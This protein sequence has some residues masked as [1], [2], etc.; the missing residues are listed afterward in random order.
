MADANKASKIEAK[1]QIRNEEKSDR[2]DEFGLGV[3]KQFRPDWLDAENS[4]FINKLNFMSKN[5]Q[6]TYNIVSISDLIYN[7][8]LSDKKFKA[9]SI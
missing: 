8:F 1:E 5:Y 2:F 9:Y 6:S 3:K 7:F 4:L